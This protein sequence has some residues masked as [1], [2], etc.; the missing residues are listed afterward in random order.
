[1]LVEPI[2]LNPLTVAEQPK[3]SSSDRR[4]EI[5]DDRVR[6]LAARQLPLKHSI[7]VDRNGANSA[8]EGRSI[9][10][11]DGSKVANHGGALSRASL[12]SARSS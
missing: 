10:G 2:R 8:R 4:I 12:L 6:V 11:L 9:S 3:P 7:D 1:M 5:V